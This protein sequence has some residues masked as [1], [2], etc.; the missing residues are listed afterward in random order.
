MYKVMASQKS[1]IYGVAA[2]FPDLDL[3]YVGLHTGK[4]TTPCTSKFLLSHL[5]AFCEGIM[6]KVNQKNGFYFLL[7]AVG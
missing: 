7:L 2:V 4:T 3:L 6:H 1:P 5:M